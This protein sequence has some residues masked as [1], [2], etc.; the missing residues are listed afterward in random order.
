M[1]KLTSTLG[2]TA[3]A[4]T[5]AGTI[6][7]PF[8]L[9]GLFA[10]GVAA[11][12]V[13]IDPAYS[14]GTISHRLSRPGYDIEVYLPVRPHGLL[15]R[16][17]PFVQLAW[18]PAAALPAHISDSVDIDDDGQPELQVSFDVPTNA[19]SR[20]RAEVTALSPRF[21]SGKVPDDNANPFASLLERTRDRVILR[22]ERFQGP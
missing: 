11:T 3:A 14:G 4:L 9:I 6:L 15:S 1:S 7:A 20:P 13:Q 12:G 22:V 18:T 16:V 10:R 21:R 5:I 2:Y 8:V 19:Q 17:E